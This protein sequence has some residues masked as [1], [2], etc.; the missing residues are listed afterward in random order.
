MRTYILKRL[1]LMIPTLFGVSLVIWVLVTSAPGDEVVVSQEEAQSQEGT[2]GGESRRIFRAQF[3]LD[4]P[5]FWND[6][7]DLTPEEVLDA[8]RTANDRGLPFKER[9]EAFD[10]LED[11]SYFAVPRLAAALDLTDDIDLKRQLLRRLARNAKRITPATLGQMLTEEDR[12]RNREV[13]TENDDIKERLALGKEPTPEE[14]REKA[15]LWKAWVEERKDRWTWEGGDRLEVQLLDTRFAKYW[16]NL[17]QLDFG[18]SQAHRKPVLTLIGERI[19]VSLALAVISLILAYA[20]SVPLG[21]WS[22]VR[23]KTMREQTVGIVLFMLYSLP[24]F[25][26]ATLVLKYVGVDWDLIPVFGFESINTFEM[27]SWKHFLDIAHHV[28]APIFCM[29]YVSLAA[30]SRYAKSG[31]LNVIRADYIRTARA[32]GLKERV[33]IL[34][35]ALRNGIMPVVTLLGTTLPVI[36]GGSV[37]IETIFL[38]PGMGALMIESIFARDYNV[39]IGITMITAVLTMIGILVSDILYAVIDPRISYT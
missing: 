27:T 20:L 33:V 7:V 6:Y 39:V 38:I 1:L 17:I 11:W 34:K 21:V 26:A 23:H 24:S 18:I 15:L 37:V 28:V 19:R 30:L 5:L 29:T 2:G 22:A 3:N 14:I 9:N 8:V 25:F 4:K 12:A 31:I 35:H 13:Q 36:V 10:K 32:K 16:A